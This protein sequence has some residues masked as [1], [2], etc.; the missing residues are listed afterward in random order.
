MILSYMMLY[1]Q[2]SV[3]V[4]PQ[5][6]FLFAYKIHQYIESFLEHH[7]KVVEVTIFLSYFSGAFTSIILLMLPGSLVTHFPPL[8]A[9]MPSSRLNIVLYTYILCSMCD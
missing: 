2:V 4:A 6:G 1:F 3:S 8:L 5:V 9:V 7:A